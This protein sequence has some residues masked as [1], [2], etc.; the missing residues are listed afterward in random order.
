[1]YV[2]DKLRCVWIWTDERM[3]T[4]YTS[5]GDFLK[6]HFRA[7]PKFKP[8]TSQDVGGFT[9]KLAK[10]QVWWNIKGLQWLRWLGSGRMTLPENGCLYSLEVNILLPGW[11]CCQASWAQTSGSRLFGHLWIGAAATTAATQYA[12][13]QVRRI[14]SLSSSIIDSSF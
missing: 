4:W 5:H 13:L 11:S 8:K 6:N 12:C 1:M 10:L 7:S 9:E 2:I 3:V 14:H